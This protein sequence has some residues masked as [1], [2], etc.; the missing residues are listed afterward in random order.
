MNNLCLAGLHEHF[1]EVM[2]KAPSNAPKHAKE[3][4]CLSWVNNTN[5]PNKG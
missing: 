5:C 3:C 4:Q 1:N 2:P